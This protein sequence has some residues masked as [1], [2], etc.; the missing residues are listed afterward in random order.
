MNAVEIFI[1]MVVRLFV[2]FIIRYLNGLAMRIEGTELLKKI[3]EESNAFGGFDE[4]L[5]GTISRDFPSN[6]AQVEKQLRK[7]LRFYSTL[8]KTDEES[9]AKYVVEKG[10]R[11]K[12]D[13]CPRANP[14]PKIDKAKSAFGNKRLT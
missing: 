2:M 7:V 11:I 12:I 8:K 3:L 13:M 6:S 4:A 14:I 5:K 1:L 10:I 9:A